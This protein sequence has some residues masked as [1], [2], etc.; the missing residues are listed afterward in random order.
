MF[1]MSTDAGAA[2]EAVVAAVGAGLAIAWS[3]KN[4]VAT[5]VGGGADDSNFIPSWELAKYN[6][7]VIPRPAA[8]SFLSL[9]NLLT[10]SPKSLL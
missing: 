7:L 6:K 3:L 8:Y 2:D 9:G 10:S 4:F 1:F 5:S